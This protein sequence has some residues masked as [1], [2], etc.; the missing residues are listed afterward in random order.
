MSNPLIF[1]IINLF[2]VEMI[3]QSKANKIV[4]KHDSNPKPKYSIYTHTHTHTHT[5]RPNS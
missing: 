1:D 3:S 5:N 4:N 2:S